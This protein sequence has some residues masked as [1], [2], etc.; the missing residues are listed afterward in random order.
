[1]TA[2]TNAAPEAQPSPEGDTARPQPDA[3]AQPEADTDAADEAVDDVADDT[4][5]DDTGDEDDQGDK[6]RASREAA[7]WRT[8]YKQTRDSLVETTAALEMLR[9]D[10]I[11]DAVTRRGF[12]ERFS[13]LMQSSGVELDSLLS[14]AGGVDRAKLDTAITETARRFN[15]QPNRRPLPVRGQGQSG[16]GTGGGARL[17]DMLKQ[18]AGG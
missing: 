2:P 9:Q 7:K 16:S 8:R 17:G 10:V 11:D 6:G 18:A 12:D 4:D 3:Q 15:I 13:D 14:A 1:M 5:Q